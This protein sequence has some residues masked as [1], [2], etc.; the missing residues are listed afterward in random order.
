MTRSAD[1]PMLYNYTIQLRG[2]NLQNVNDKSVKEADRAAELGFGEFT[3]Q[4]KFAKFTSVV[5]NAATL[6]SA[7]F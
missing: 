5:G 3:G 6:I 2:F 4:S 1:N 7:K